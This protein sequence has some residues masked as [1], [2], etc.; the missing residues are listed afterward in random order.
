[1][2]TAFHRKQIP[3]SRGSK[4]RGTGIRYT[5]ITATSVRE[6]TADELAAREEQKATFQAQRGTRGWNIHCL[7]TMAGF[8]LDAWEDVILKE[9]SLDRDYATERI[10]DKALT[11][12][13]TAVTKHCDT[14]GI[15]VDLLIQSLQ[16]PQRSAALCSAL[17]SV[18]KRFSSVFDAV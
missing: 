9:K 5:D 18:C 2:G 3:L 1:M 16:R 8:A 13:N 14:S 11:I 4:T 15:E 17:A 6:L 12:V 7:M 10:V